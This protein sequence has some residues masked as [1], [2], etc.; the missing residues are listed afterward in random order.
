[1]FSWRQ[2]VALAVHYFRVKIW[3][4]VGVRVT[5]GVGVGVGERGY[6][7]LKYVFFDKRGIQLARNPIFSYN[8]GC[9]FEIIYER[10]LFVESKVFINRVINIGYINFSSI[11]S[12]VSCF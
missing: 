6:C 10:R 4:K 2:K 12:R 5:V 3:S 1:M 9:V 11:P 8:R 7:V